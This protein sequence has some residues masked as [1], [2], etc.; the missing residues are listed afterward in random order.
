MVE[1]KVYSGGSVSTQA[2]DASRFGERVFARTLKDAVVMYE[3]NQSP[4]QRQ[5]QVARRGRRPE[6]EDVEAEAHRARPHGFEEGRALAWWRHGVRPAGRVTTPTKCPSRP[7][8]LRCATRSTPS[9]VDGEVC[10]ADGWPAEKPNTKQRGC[11]PGRARPRAERSRRDRRDSIATST[12]RC[13][14][15]RRSMSRPVAD[16]NALTPSSPGATW[17]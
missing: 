11:H 12:S 15:C 14:T 10:V 5:D 16:L 13:A 7:A 1:V 9:S 8:G 6:L 17:C 4:G 2:V 3:A